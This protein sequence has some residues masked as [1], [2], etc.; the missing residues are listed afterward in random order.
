MFILI[1]TTRCWIEKNEEGYREQ[2]HCHGGA[3]RCLESDTCIV[4]PLN[5]AQHRRVLD[6][7]PNCFLTV[8]DYPQRDFCSKNI[9]TFKIR[10]HKNLEGLVGAFFSYCKS[11][12]RRKRAPSQSY[13]GARRRLLLYCLKRRS[14]R[15]FWKATIRSRKYASGRFGKRARNAG[16]SI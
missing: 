10:F 13:C 5:S 15:H 6:L 16:I 8:V 3:N 9:L 2:Q 1:E 7:P 12:R 14:Y 4:M 11:T